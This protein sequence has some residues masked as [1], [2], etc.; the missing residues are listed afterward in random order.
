MPN[1]TL[2]IW[3]PTGEAPNTSALLS[4]R[5]ARPSA[6]I[7]YDLPQEHQLENLL[8]EVAPEEGAAEGAKEGSG[9]DWTVDETNTNN[10]RRKSLPGQNAVVLGENSV[11]M[12]LPES[13][14]NME[15]KLDLS[16]PRALAVS[17][18][19]DKLSLEGSCFQLVL[20]RA[21]PQSR[22][23]DGYVDAF[24]RAP[25]CIQVGALDVPSSN[26]CLY[27]NIWTPP[28]CRHTEKG[29]K[30]VI[31][32][33][34]QDWFR[35]TRFTTSPAWKELAASEDVVV[36]VPSHR[37]GLLGFLNTGNQGIPGNVGLFDLLLALRWIKE[38][39]A[40]F[41]GD[42][43]SMVALG[44][45]SGAAMLTLAL[46][47]L[48]RRF[49]KRA[50]LQDMSPFTMMPRNDRHVGKQ[51]ALRLCR[52][53]G[54][55]VHAGDVASL[56]LQRSYSEGTLLS[57]AVALD[58]IWFMPSFDQEPLIYPPERLVDESG[59]DGVDLLCGV[60]RRA[61]EVLFQRHLL[62]LL[63][64]EGGLAEKDETRVVAKLLTFFLKEITKEFEDN[65]P[66]LID[67]IKAHY[68]PI[69]G[70]AYAALKEFLEDLVYRCPMM[71]FADAVASVGS[72]SVFHFVGTSNNS[73]SFILSASQIA[74]FLKS[75]KAPSLPGGQSW[76]PY[77]NDSRY[78][79]LLPDGTP[80][81]PQQERC[82]VARRVH[83]YF[84]SVYGTGFSAS[85]QVTDTGRR[86]A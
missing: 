15:A 62:T 53:L 48:G 3:S 39:A 61:A 18:G 29:N 58:E 52:L 70:S 30:T 65:L 46:R 28:T 4:L 55:H 12:V 26:D 66:Q 36:V 20:N 23:D 22:F 45:G 13:W 25:P 84:W 68:G 9:I 21:E 64:T 14:S 50:V 60:D 67:E 42:A 71:Q 40:E 63:K 51:R 86:H 76:A 5:K 59:L 74:H 77:T 7:V 79:V 38:N 37:V 75:G 35:T 11:S 24:S 19:E 69:N 32:A 41:G 83:D 16:K 73:H 56:Y 2:V 31:V 47:S 85:S 72:G 6:H 43:D 57:Y 8:E 27:L 17:I 82:K 49:F 81:E 34:V 10:C 80:A 33:L 1:A 54:C 78:T 44:H